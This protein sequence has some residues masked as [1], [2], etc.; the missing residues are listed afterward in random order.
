MFR[1]IKI[2]FFFEVFEVLKTK[3][4]AFDKF[5]EIIGRFSL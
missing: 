5:D 2:R 1:A 3:G 4:I